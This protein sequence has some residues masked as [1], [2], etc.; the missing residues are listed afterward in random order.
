MEQQEITKSAGKLADLTFKLLASCH[1]KEERLAKKH[2]LTQAEF[3]C[4]RQIG[5][6][7]NINNKEIAERMN[8]SASRLTRIIDG[9]VAKGYV[10]REIQPNDRRNMRLYLSENGKTFT[11]RLN[12]DYINIHSQ[13]LSDIDAGQHQP[14]IGAMTGLLTAVEK[15][16]AQQE[17]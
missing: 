1:E 14:L 15:W 4:L 8:L 16:M 11:H 7:E 17:S 5:E 10:V 3:R 2:N 9:L 6:T 12:D 13:I